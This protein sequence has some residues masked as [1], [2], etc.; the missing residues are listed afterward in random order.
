MMK[1]DYGVLK[2]WYSEKL[3]IGGMHARE[4]KYLQRYVVQKLTRICVC[5][6]LHM[7]FIIFRKYVR[8]FF[9]ASRRYNIIY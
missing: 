2:K 4:L 5:T 7:L 8:T 6:V 1:L 3:V 9:S